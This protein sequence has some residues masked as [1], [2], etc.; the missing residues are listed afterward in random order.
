MSESAAHAMI[1]L[2]VKCQ[3]WGGMSDV[4]GPEV[5]IAWSKSGQLPPEY[6]NNFVP[7]GI[8]D[9]LFT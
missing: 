2:A 8:A 6:R 5:P 3:Y 1:G 9:P 7:P 4:E